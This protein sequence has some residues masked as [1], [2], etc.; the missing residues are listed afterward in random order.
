MIRFQRLVRADQMAVVFK[1]GEASDELAA[2]IVIEVVDGKVGLT[3]VRCRMKSAFSRFSPK[4][5][6]FVLA[7]HIYINTFFVLFF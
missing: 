1:D 4:S 3:V 7:L 2:Q 5:S 6:A